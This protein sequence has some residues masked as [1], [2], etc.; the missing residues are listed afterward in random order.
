[1]G[2]YLQNE[3]KVLSFECEFDDTRNLYGDLMYYTLNYYLSDDTVEIKEKRG[4]NSG[5]DPFPLLLKRA[6][7]PSEW[8]LE[9]TND[10][11]RGVEEDNTQDNFVTPDDVQIGD[12]IMV[13]GRLLKVVDCDQFTRTWY[14]SNPSMHPAGEQGPSC[15]FVAATIEA[16]QE[17]PPA[18]NGY[19]TEKD[20]LGSCTHLIPKVPK[21][22]FDKYMANASKILR[23]KARFVSGTCRPEH[24]DRKFVIAYFPEDDTQSIFE[25]A[26]RNSG[27]VGGKF[28]ERG[29]YK[30]T[31]G[32]LY[33]E[34]DFD[35]GANVVFNSH[36]FEIY[37]MDKFT[38]SKK[39][40]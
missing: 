34:D 15:R 9:G 38:E 18:Y 21:K 25:I 11:D 30:S 31:S 13:Y 6:K 28:L 4:A 36:Q 40:K 2:Q 1:M 3:G 27:I 24:A 5:R 12:Q 32:S 20:S 29:A 22:N 17:V 14:S 16:R 19:G 26:A 7:L 10:R 23:F 37:E 8:M 35:I 39:G 33:T